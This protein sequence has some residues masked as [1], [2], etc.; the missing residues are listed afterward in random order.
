MYHFE[1]KPFFKN[2]WDRDFEKFFAKADQLVPS[3]EIL[4]QEKFYTISLD[5]PGLKKEDIDLEVRDHQLHVCGERKA[6]NIT[7]TENILR[8]EKRYGKFSRSFTLPDNIKDDAIEAHF[9]N[10]VLEILLPK[11][12]KIQPKKV[13]IN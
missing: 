4:D 13:T 12:E 7:E 2:T 8:S 10:G 6:Q 11:E 9:E 5:V 3:C 1:L